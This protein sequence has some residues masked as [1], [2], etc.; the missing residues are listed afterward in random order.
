MMRAAV[1][2]SVLFCTSSRVFG[3]VAEAPPTFEVASIKP[4]PPPTGG[5]MRVGMSGGPGS[6]DPGR[7]TF[8]NMS[9][10]NILMRAYEVKGYQISGPGWLDSERFDIVAKVPQGATKEQ[11][12]LMIQNL[13]AERF[14]LTLHREKKELP[15][16]AL[17]V[18]KNGPKLK[19]SV[20]DPNANDAPAAGGGFPPP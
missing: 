2:L 18:G 15:M 13:L 16:F 5:M 11:F 8:T 10:K 19:E 4:A 20:D 12:L 6:P 14:K 9:L 7:A 1:G 17:L 3:Q